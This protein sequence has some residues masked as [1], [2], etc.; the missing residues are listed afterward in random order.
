MEKR[1][2]PEPS[3]IP[4]RADLVTLCR[5]LNA[6]GARYIVVGGMAVIQQGYVRATD[7][8]DLLLDKSPQNIEKVRSALEILPDKAILEMQPGDLENYT[9]VRVADEILVDLMLSTCGISYEQAKD[10]I[11]WMEI[12]DV[13]IPFATA[14]L[15]LK[16]KQTGRE[17]DRLDL[18]FLERKIAGQE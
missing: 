4:E 17:K 10:E 13:P 6:R 11:E 18:M 12:D 3:R 1:P 16:M 2:A 8:I 9:V 5:A 15:L 7:D 14:T